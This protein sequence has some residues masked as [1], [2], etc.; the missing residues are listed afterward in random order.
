MKNW[1]TDF[2]GACERSGDLPSIHSLPHYSPR[3]AEMQSAATSSGITA[4]IEKTARRVADWFNNSQHEA[5][6]EKL[7]KLV[8]DVLA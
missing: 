5:D 7:R 3:V 2:D 8:K 4:R 1:A 6:V